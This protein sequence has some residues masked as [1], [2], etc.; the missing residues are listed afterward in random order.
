M[1][2]ETR[3]AR[4]GMWMVVKCRT[5]CSTIAMDWVMRRAR[6]K[7]MEAARRIAGLDPD[8]AAGNPLNFL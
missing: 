6:Y 7:G 1:D 3:K 8:W 4:R 2:A 5:I